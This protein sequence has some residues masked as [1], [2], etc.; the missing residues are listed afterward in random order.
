MNDLLVSIIITLI[1]I[2]HLV[3]LIIGYKMQKTSLIISYLNTITVIGVSA[4]W[5][6]TIPN[7]KQ[8]NFEFRE[9]LVICLETCIL[10]FALYSIIG[11]H[12]KAY[13]KVINFIGFGVHLLTT[14][15][16]FYYMFAFKFD[17]LF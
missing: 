5:A 6:I 13:V 12:N 1:L 17:K 10:I 11:F 8:H 2:S 7:I 3:A 15:I 9:L 4:F 16:M 14:I